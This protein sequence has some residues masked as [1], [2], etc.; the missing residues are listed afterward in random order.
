MPDRIADLYQRHAHA[1]DASRRRAFPERQWLER[2][3]RTLPKDAGILDLGCGGGEPIARFLIDRGFHITG[4]DIA[5]SMI[6][7]ART[8]FHRHSWVEADMCRFGPASASYDGII[9]WSSLFHLEHDLQEKMIRRIGVWLKHGGMALFNSG[10]D[11]GVSIGELGG[12][13]LYHASLAPAEYR[14][15]FASSGLVEIAHKAQDPGC[16]G[17]TVWLV[18]RA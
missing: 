3:A 14:A 13:P 6:Q 12:E 1:F 2:F 17:M 4:V 18:R 10:P 11:R 9:A 7:L 8:R 5:P 16:G 15:L